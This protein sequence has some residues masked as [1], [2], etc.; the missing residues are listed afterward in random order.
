MLR[1]TRE[2]VE[3]HSNTCP[4]LGLMCQSMMVV[5]VCPSACP[6][7]VLRKLP[8]CSRGCQAGLCG[9]QVVSKPTG[10]PY[11]KRSCSSLQPEVSIRRH[12]IFYFLKTS[13]R[14]NSL[15]GV[16]VVMRRSHLHCGTGAKGHLSTA[17][18]ASLESVSC[19]KKNLPGGIL[20]SKSM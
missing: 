8:L 15:N 2:G 12:S 13:W 20:V 1:C 16:P 19:M 6:P 17:E 9:G 4:V 11:M 14:K 18:W 5:T 7:E 10:C 3:N